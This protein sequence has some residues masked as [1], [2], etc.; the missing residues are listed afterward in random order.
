MRKL[1]SSN[2][3][4][5][6]WEGGLFVSTK[7]ANVRREKAAAVEDMAAAVEDMAAA[8]VEDM[9]AEDAVDVVVEVEVGVVGQVEDVAH[10]VEVVERANAGRLELRLF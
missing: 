8:A 10:E 1:P 2:S 4:A 7:L 9:A 3:M 6:C 5:R